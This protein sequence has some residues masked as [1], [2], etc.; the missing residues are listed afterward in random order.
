M[1]IKKK[2]ANVRSINKMDYRKSF[3]TLS[4]KKTKQKGERCIQHPQRYRISKAAID[5]DH[6]C[7]C[8]LPLL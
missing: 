8:K 6:C 3:V 5:H 7:K 2:K 1:K 4:K